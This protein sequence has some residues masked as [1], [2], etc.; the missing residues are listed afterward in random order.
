MANPTNASWGCGTNHVTLHRHSENA[1]LRLM[2]FRISGPASS[3][4]YD[5]DID[6]PL[7][8]RVGALIATHLNA[9]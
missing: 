6:A 8:R 2:L 1:A 3:Q 7:L 4:T 5:G 9:P